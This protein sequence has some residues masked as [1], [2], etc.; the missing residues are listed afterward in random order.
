MITANIATEMRDDVFSLGCTVWD[1]VENRPV[2][3]GYV[4]L[5]NEAESRP[6]EASDT[7][8]SYAAY[9]RK[10]K[11]AGARYVLASCLFPYP[12]GRVR[13][14]MTNAHAE[15]LDECG[16]LAE[17][18]LECEYEFSLDSPRWTFYQED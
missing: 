11:E 7:E 14:A 4:F 6:V 2:D 12:G 16:G 15:G 10:A 17:F 1:V 5:I 8:E 18:F 3:T 13:F 9:I